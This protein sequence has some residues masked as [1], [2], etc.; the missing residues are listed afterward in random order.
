MTKRNQRMIIQMDK[1]DK[2]D[3]ML[4]LAEFGANR[5]ERRRTI[6]FQIFISYTT[7][8]VLGI[9]VII[10]NQNEVTN[11]FKNDS[12]I[13]LFLALAAINFIYIMWQ[14]G[15]CR[16]MENDNVRRNFYVDKAQQ[17]IGIVP[18]EDIRGEKKESKIVINRNYLDQFRDFHLIFTHWPR[19]LLLGI[20]TILHVILLFTVYEVT[21]CS[22]WIFYIS[23]IATVF[24]PITIIFIMF[25]FEKFIL[26]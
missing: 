18:N 17:L 19:L 8:V 7:L 14:V 5:M 24:I 1:K 3:A 11:V 23:A 10:K 26:P 2:F 25:I 12:V 9:Y 22:I 21:N 4:T 15:L 13:F 20:P 6:E 16:A